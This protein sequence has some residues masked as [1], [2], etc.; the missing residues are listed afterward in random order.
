MTKSILMSAVLAG[1]MLC[2][3]FMPDGKKPWNAPAA[4]ASKANPQKGPASISNGKALFAKHCQS[5]HG[6][7]GMGDGTKASELKTEPGDFSKG[8]FQSQSDGSIFYKISEGRDDMP[9]FKKK[10]AD[11]NDV[12]DV[13]NY[14]RTLKK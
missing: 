14:L 11:A 6:K 9:S 3:A 8:G 2:F 13:V 1:S 4:S 10:I 7:S 12:W 5:C